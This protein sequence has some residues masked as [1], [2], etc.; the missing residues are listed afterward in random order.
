MERDTNTPKP[1]I[2]E[3]GKKS[4]VVVKIPNREELTQK[5]TDSGFYG[6]SPQTDRFY[7]SFIGKIA[8]S[9][10]VGGGLALSW[11]LSIYDTLRDMPPMVV[12]AV[13]MN[14]ESVV[15]AVS[16][17]LLEDAMDF[18]RQVQEEK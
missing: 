18:R 16:P 5:L 10:K 11:A 14:F 12:A 8:G 17:E 9:E 2:N 4:E 6:V 3:T 7:D 1:G 15:G 13:E